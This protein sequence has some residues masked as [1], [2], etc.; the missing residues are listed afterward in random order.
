L[1]TFSLSPESH[2]KWYKNVRKVQY[3][4]SHKSISSI[5]SSS[6]LPRHQTG[7]TWIYTESH[8]MDGKERIILVQK[9]ERLKA[10]KDKKGE[11]G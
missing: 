6:F 1:D 2:H 7:K 10:R 8:T 11:E 5:V 4:T 9:W 3:E